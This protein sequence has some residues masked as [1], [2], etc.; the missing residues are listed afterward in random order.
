[1]GFYVC[2]HLV[3]LRRHVVPLRR[4]MKPQRRAEELQNVGLRNSFCRLLGPLLV[5]STGAFVGLTLPTGL[6]PVYMAQLHAV[7]NALL[8]LK[9]KGA[10]ITDCERAKGEV[11]TS[12]KGVAQS[13]I[14]ENAEDIMPN[15]RHVSF[16]L[17]QKFESDGPN[18]T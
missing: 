4:H 11:T 8:A 17:F 5:G 12:C 7:C 9:G 2:R 14:S 10:T 3:S 13:V 15:L 18:C 16:L 1:M 6:L